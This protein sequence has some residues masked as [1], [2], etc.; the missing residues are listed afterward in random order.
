[1]KGNRMGKW[2]VLL[3]VVGVV[4]TLSYM[5]LVM[6]DRSR[7]RPSPALMAAAEQGGLE[8]LKK[9]A[10][11]AKKAAQD[12]AE[13][14][15]KGAEAAKQAAMDVAD[16][17]NP[18]MVQPEELEQGF[19]VVVTDKSKVASSSSPIHMASS[20]NGWNPADTRMQLTAQSDMKWR[21]VWDK[22]KLDSRIAFKFA[23]GSWEA[24]ET[25]PDFKDV[26]NRMLPKIDVSKLKPGEK[27][28]IELSIETWKDQMPGN[29]AF[30]ASNRYRKIEVGA[31]RLERVEAVGGGAWPDRSRDVLVWLPPGYDEAANKSRAYPV[32][33]LQ[34]GQNLFEKLPTVPGDWQA[35]ETASRL[36]G[37]GK[38]E[39]LIIVGV[40]NSGDLRG[41]EYLPIPIPGFENASGG[42][43]VDFLVNEL[44]P[45]IERAYRVKA[46]PENTAI[47]GSSLGAVISMEAA[48]R[49]PQV[50][51]KV[52]LESMPTR[53]G[54]GVLFRHFGAMK[55]WPKQMY[56]GV[57]G[58]EGG[59]SGTDATNEQFVEGLR[60]LT[61]TARGKGLK[62][63]DVKFVV[64]EQ[65]THTE[66]AWAERFGPAL[67]FLFPP[68]K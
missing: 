11:D 54:Q 57:G 27:P 38:I 44:R 62:D 50:F 29:P 41:Q 7:G 4:G 32:L 52:L 12:A 6:F 28:V 59:P 53:P 2:F 31:G 24:V 34:D 16:A 42:Q 25:T 56:V 19:I 48:C 22:P 8:G 33:Y 60:A 67:E 51:G 45:R 35:D 21:I 49:Y 15:K 46:G 65:A 36:I 1:M 17:V 55:S 63:S 14:A 18:S 37:E 58:K 64:D 43:Y 20:H 26:D 13:Q 47:G 66:S 10:D 40:P 5:Q 61:E 23:R 39:P 30:A 9:S 68:V 3:W